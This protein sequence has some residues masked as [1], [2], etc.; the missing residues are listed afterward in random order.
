MK[1]VSERTDRF[2]LLLHAARKLGTRDEKC[3]FLDAVCKDDPALLADLVATITLESRPSQT[4]A[5]SDSDPLRFLKGQLVADRFEIV[6]LLGEGGMAAVYEAFDRKLGERRALK[7][8]KLGHDQHIPGEARQA[9]RVTHDNICRTHEIHTTATNRGP[10]D[11][12]S[13][14]LIEG[15][16]LRRR[17]RREPMAGDEAVEIACQL[18]RGLDA[19]HGAQV[20]HR[21]LKSNNVMLTLRGD[22]TPRAVIMDFG[23]AL[24]VDVGSAGM[25]RLSGTPNYIPPERWKGGEA[26]PAGDLYALGVILYE[27]LT[28]ELPFAPGTP[29]ARRLSEVPELPSRSNRK[30]DPRW[31]RIV[32]GCLEPEPSNRFSTAAEV[33]RAIERTFRAGPSRRWLLVAAGLALALTPVA[34]FRERIW[35]PPLVR[36]AVLP[37][38]GSMR[39]P[40]VDQAAKGALFDLGRQLESLG[41]S[42]QRMVLIPLEESLRHQVINPAVA[43][44]RLGATHVLTGTIE[45][46]DRGFALRAAITDTRTGVS[47]KRFDGEFRDTDLSSLPAALAGVVTA[48]FHLRQTAPARIGAPAY[49][50]YAA[51]LAGLRAVPPDLDKAISSFQ[52]AVKRDAD[53]APAFS[54]LADAYLEKYRLQRDGDILARATAASERAQSLQPDSPDVLLTL[55]TIQELQ[56]RT[57]PAID[58]FKRAAELQPR[59]SEAW[60]RIGIAF[61]SVGRD[62]EAVEALRRSVQLAPDYYAPHRALGAIYYRIG[63][64]PEAVEEFRIVTQLAPGLAEGFSNLAAALVGVGNDPEAEQALRRSISLQPTRGA[65]NNLGVLLRFGGHDKDAVPVFEQAL[66]AGA[67]DAG[68]RLNLANALRRVGRMAEARQHLERASELSRA[69]LRANPRDAIAR[70]RLA[71]TMV[72]LGPLALAADEALQAARLSPSDY[73]VLLWAVITLDVCGRRPEALALLSDAPY[74]RLRELRRQPDLA[75]FVRDPRF[76]DLLQHSQGSQFT[77]ERKKANVRSN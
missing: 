67:D 65:L 22:G 32:V 19:A 7:F 52:E 46:R 15:E 70:A 40:A 60:R 25:A 38:D 18:C 48:A 51:G 41:A 21:D 17:L 61:Q 63:R 62:T 12:L 31:D 58:F 2:L 1:P 57:E 39:D 77:S 76:V 29:W 55:G 35:P 13:M 27:M 72:R 16:T 45:A 26:T 34:V 36:L 54:G 53:A 42:S 33:L 24:P 50:Y 56:G 20:L 11:F 37:F 9:L 30:P 71:Y 4:E 3:A 68:V 49:A 69:A 10:A 5:L 28:G 64:L 44:S 6:R 23:L 66:Q 14:E 43:A 8:P 75:E 59:N 73:S 74:E 47:L